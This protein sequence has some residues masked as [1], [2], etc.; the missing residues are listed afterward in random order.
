[1]GVRLLCAARTA[2]V[3]VVLKLDEVLSVGDAYFAHKSFERIREMT[4]AHG[5]TLLIVS[6]DV[7]RTMMLCNRLVWIDGGRIR[8]DG[9]AKDVANRYQLSVREQEEQRLRQRRV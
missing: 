6:H 4:D 7:D 8:M 5:S 2:I 1:M 9:N 3:P